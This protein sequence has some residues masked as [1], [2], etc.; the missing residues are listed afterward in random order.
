MSGRDEGIYAPGESAERHDTINQFEHALK[1]IVD[2]GLFYF[3]LANAG[4][5]W[6][7]ESIWDQ[8]STAVFLGLGIGK[9]IG[10]SLFTIC[11]F[12]LLNSFR[13]QELPTKN[14]IAMQWCDVLPIGILG[15]MGFT[16]ALFVA[17]AAG[18]APSLK[19][20]A[21]ASFLYLGLGVVVGKFLCKKA[22]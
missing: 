6:I 4:V 11:G 8:N 13:K 19:I 12:A 3:G 15:A 22:E 14:G 9:T 7:G 2:I 21:L 5:A 10:I 18:G 16:V 1:P 20:G 17:D